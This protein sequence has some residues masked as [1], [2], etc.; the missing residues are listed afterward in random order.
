MK[1]MIV[2][3]FPFR[4]SSFLN[5]TAI[6]NDDIYKKSLDAI[7][8]T[9]K[10][11]YEQETSLVKEIFDNIANRVTQRLAQRNDKS[12]IVIDPVAKL[13]TSDLMKVSKQ[14]TCMI[15]F[16]IDIDE[17]DIGDD[18]NKWRYHFDEDEDES[19]LHLMYINNIELELLTEYH[20][21]KMDI[22][23]DVIDGGQGWKTYLGYIETDT[24]LATLNDEELLNTCPL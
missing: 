17:E 4:D 3:V 12:V 23:S 24:Y 14:C 6:N 8:D 15:Y 16:D 2:Y 22:S 5:M 7:A 19:R 11:L 20:W 13:L 21:S 10:I 18:S 9:R 1:K